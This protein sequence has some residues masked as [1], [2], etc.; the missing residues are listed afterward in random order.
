MGQYAGANTWPNQI[1]QFE[2]TDV[3]KGGPDGKDNLPV[4]QLAD[5]TEFLK[6]AT[7]GFGGV[8]IYTDA[9]VELAKNDVFSKLIILKGSGKQSL[10]LPPLQGQDAGLRLKIVNHSAGIIA[11]IQSAEGIALAAGDERNAIYLAGGES[12]SLVWAANKWL[13][14]DFY[15]NLLKAGTLN[16]G[17]QAAANS[18]IANGSLLSRADYPRLWAFAQSLASS[19][20]EDRFW[21]T[22]TGFKGF[23]TA[24]NGATNFRIPDLRGMFIR[25]LDLGAGISFARNQENPGGYEDD[26][27]KSHNHKQGSESLYNNYGGGNYIGNRNWATDYGHPAYTDQNTAEKGGQETRPKN[28]GLIPYLL[29]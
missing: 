1:Y 27:F 21:T 28:I 11:A 18:V 5:R 7:R 29:F 4:K 19:L 3:V 8:V 24:G 10:N 15:G 2:T 22:Y 9:S 23:F 13:V 26:D 12:L 20:I 14:T 25:G 6:Q 16:Y 17:Y